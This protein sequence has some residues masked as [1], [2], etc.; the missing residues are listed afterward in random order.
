MRDE[1]YRARSVDDAAVDSI[2][3]EWDRGRRADARGAVRAAL[4]MLPDPDACVVLGDDVHLVSG[5]CL[6]T[7]SAPHDTGGT[8][9]ECKCEGHVIGASA[10]RFELVA[11]ETSAMRQPWLTWTFY[12]WPDHDGLELALSFEQ[13][14]ALPLVR[15]LL[16]RLSI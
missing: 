12:L 14:E 10:P 1:R 2:V 15:E 11:R 3:S 8:E 7:L 5:R 6:Y 13:E 9:A 16:S 4:G